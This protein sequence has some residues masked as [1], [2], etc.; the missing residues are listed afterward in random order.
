MPGIPEASAFRLT[1]YMD[2]HGISCDDPNYY[3]LRNEKNPGAEDPYDSEHCKE[4]R[5]E[6]HK[7][8]DDLERRNQFEFPHIQRLWGSSAEECW[9]RR[10]SEA[11]GGGILD[12]RNTK[13]KPLA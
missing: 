3:P 1:P 5:A 13:K 11:C 6:A 9:D 8:C 10:V 7:F 2:G 4:Q 12:M